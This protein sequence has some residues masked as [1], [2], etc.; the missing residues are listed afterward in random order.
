MEIKL[1]IGF[2]EKSYNKTLTDT[3]FNIFR[4]KK[5][6]DKINNLQGFKN[7]EFLITGGSDRSGF[8]MRRDI[9]GTLRKNIRGNTISDDIAQ[10][11]LKVLK[12]GDKKIEE[13]FGK[14]EEAKEEKKT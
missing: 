3:E 12:E 10:I 6:G 7:Y 1:C 5:V 8:P 9:E 4:G 11:N 2:K 13:L 14:T